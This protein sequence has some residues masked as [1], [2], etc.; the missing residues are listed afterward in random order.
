[1]LVNLF[2]DMM[3]AYQHDHKMVT[4]DILNMYRTAY[5]E[6]DGCQAYYECFILALFSMVLNH[7]ES[8]S[9]HRILTSTNFPN[10][11]LFYF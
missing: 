5:M 2:V 4:N 10:Q 11:S 3:I 6:A 9:D 8:A 7:K 1:M